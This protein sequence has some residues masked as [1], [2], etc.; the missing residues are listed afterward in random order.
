MI[1]TGTSVALT[2]SFHNGLAT[3]SQESSAS[4]PESSMLL[5]TSFGFGDSNNP[6]ADTANPCDMS[7]TM[8]GEA[9]KDRKVTV[10]KVSPAMGDQTVTQVSQ[11]GLDGHYSIQAQHDRIKQLLSNLENTYK[12]EHDNLSEMT[13]TDT[14]EY[15]DGSSCMFTWTPQDKLAKYGSCRFINTFTPTTWYLKSNFKSEKSPRNSFYLSNVIAMQYKKCFTENQWPFQLPETIHQCDICNKESDELIRQYA[16][17]HNSQEFMDD[18]LRTTVNGKSTV[19]IANSFGLDIYQ[20]TVIEGDQ[21]RTR[22][23]LLENPSLPRKWF[24]VIA[25]VAAKSSLHTD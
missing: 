19:R 22:S 12:K 14:S 2:S 4:Q 13:T 3:S 5:K 20:L 25:H 18:F 8:A 1:A 21:G 6:G 17:Q 15:T 7:K 9:V 10:L 16:G 11:E 24:T 23:A